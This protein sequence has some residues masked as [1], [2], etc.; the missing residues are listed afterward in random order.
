MR[1]KPKTRYRHMD[2]E[3]A[4]EIRVRYFRREAKQA[5]LAAEYG[6]TQHTVSRIVSG[7]SWSR[8]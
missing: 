5:Q 8:A 4:R 6:V 1:Q 3:K 2:A 7:L